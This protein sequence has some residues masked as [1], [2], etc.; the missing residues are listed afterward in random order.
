M[1]SDMAKRK[2]KDPNEFPLWAEFLFRE[3]TAIKKA[4]FILEPSGQTVEIGIFPNHVSAGM[5]GAY[6][7]RDEAGQIITGTVVK[8]EDPSGLTWYQA[9]QQ[10]WLGKSLN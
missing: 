3:E 9:S 5:L 4:V 7:R 10:I 6:L 1:V 2:Q 8:T